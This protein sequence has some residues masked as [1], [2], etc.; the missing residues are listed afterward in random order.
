MITRTITAIRRNIVAWLA[1]FVALT[2]TSMAASHYIIT[3]TH[4]IKPSVLKQLRAANGKLGPAGPTGPRGETGAEGKEGKAV[5][6]KEG[7]PGS[8]GKDGK[9]GSEGPHG[10]AVAYAHIS[11]IGV[12][13]SALSTENFLAASIEHPTKENGKKEKEAGVYCISGL[14]SFTPRNVTV[15]VD[16]KSTVEP[17]FA[18]ASIGPSNNQKSHKPCG[19]EPQITVEVWTVTAPG[20]E[21]TKTTDAPFYI[22]VN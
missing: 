11:E 5:Q 6:G 12:V 15:T 21:P 2:G 14:L 16:A 8:A 13:D 17:L 20:S 3:S 9:N 18:T 7:P 10:T 19:T 22:T 4:Q 1:L